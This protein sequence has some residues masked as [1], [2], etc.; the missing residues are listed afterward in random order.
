MASIMHIVSLPCLRLGV[1]ERLFVMQVLQRSARTAFGQTF[2]MS[3][4]PVSQ[5]PI[6]S[7]CREKV[8]N[9]IQ[10]PANAPVVSQL[11]VAEC[12]RSCIHRV[13]P[14][15]SI[16]LLLDFSLFGP[17]SCPFAQDFAASLGCAARAS[18]QADSS[19]QQAASVSGLS[20]ARVTLLIPKMLFHEPPHPAASG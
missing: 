10:N 1:R 4:S 19:R 3:E 6:F 11:A 9:W 7:L 8:R 5:L 13:W 2:A 14:Y 16:A 20:G 18:R 12:N 17:S 15:Y